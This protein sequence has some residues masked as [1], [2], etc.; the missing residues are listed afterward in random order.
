VRVGEVVGSYRITGRLGAGGMGEVYLGVH[1]LIGRE[2]AI[3]VL[4]PEHTDDPGI[5]ARFFNEAKATTSIKH[6]GIVEVFDFGR[7]RDGSA[8]LVMERLVGESLGDRLRQRKRLPVGQA[9]SVIRQVAGALAAAHKLGIV[10]RD[11]KP[12]NIFIVEDP[13]VT[14]GERCKILDFGIAKLR[15]REGAFP[16][17]QGTL[18]GAP[19]YMAPEQCMGSRDVDHRAD[20]YSLGCILFEMLC[21]KT[22][23]GGKAYG[24]VLTDQVRT[25]PPPPR[26]LEPSVPAEVEALILHLLAKSADSRPRD[27]LHLLDLVHELSARLAPAMGTPYPGDLDSATGLPRLGSPFESYGDLAPIKGRKS[28]GFNPNMSAVLSSASRADAATAGVP[29]APSRGRDRSAS[30]QIPILPSSLLDSDISVPAISAAPGKPPTAG[31]SAPTRAMAPAD[32]KPLYEVRRRGSDERVVVTADGNRHAVDDRAA[33]PSASPPGRPPP[34]PA[35]PSAPPPPRPAPAS[36]PPMA[37]PAPVPPGR[38]AYRT[39]APSFDPSGGAPSPGYPAAPPGQ[40]GNQGF[41]GGLGAGFVAPPER[42]RSLLGVVVVVV[43]LAA[44]VVSAYFIATADDLDGDEAKTAAATIDAGAGGA[45]VGPVIDAG[46]TVAVRAMDAG[47]AVGDA[48]AVATTAIDAAAVAVAPSTPDAATAVAIADPQHLDDGTTT[49]GKDP[50]S[51]PDS[52]TTT[53]TGT[54]STVD[55]ETRRRPAAL[56]TLRIDSLPRGAQV[57]RKADGV[58]LGETPYEYE[59]EPQAGSVSFILRHKGYVDE[60]VTMPANRSSDR[61]LPLTRTTGADRAPT[62]H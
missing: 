28:D 61:K 41:D 48:A 24:E 27:A 52:T 18:M 47:A 49:T 33:R 6:P 45:A 60:V 26:S 53:T 59:S 46:G 32:D 23:F 51:D 44:G 34:R 2:V 22:P 35:S 56:V 30:G 5:V 40:F 8:F 43:A 17:Q 42:S 20:L 55:D 57:I 14:G 39:P 62:I 36:A 13:E 21:G 38:P 58:R 50:V 31:P 19:F 4:L 9:L 7:A 37:A 25:P 12:D 16:T 15:D 10:H 11:L 3:K 29:A 1:T 54:T